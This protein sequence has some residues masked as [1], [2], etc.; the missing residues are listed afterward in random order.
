MAIFAKIVKKL[1]VIGIKYLYN[2]I[3]KN[4]DGKISKEE[5]EIIFYELKNLS[6][7]IKKK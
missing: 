2:Y 4:D 3:D 1:I 5:L 7:I 6:K